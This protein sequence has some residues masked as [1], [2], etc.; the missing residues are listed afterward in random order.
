M[1]DGTLFLIAEFKL[2]IDK[3]RNIQQILCNMIIDNIYILSKQSR[4][5]LDY[6]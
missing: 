2:S 4:N 1:I 5:N 6:V 3:L